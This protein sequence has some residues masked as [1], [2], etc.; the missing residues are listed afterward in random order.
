M[1]RGICHYNQRKSIYTYN[2]H[3]Y[4]SS[5]QIKIYIFGYSEL[6]YP[7]DRK[8]INCYNNEI[9]T[10]IVHQRLFKSCRSK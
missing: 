5:I 8:P 1:G 6:I 3:P 7:I 4:D 10:H 9:C 2:T